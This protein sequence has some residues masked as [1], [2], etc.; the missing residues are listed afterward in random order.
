MIEG[1]ALYNK[2]LQYW[3]KKAAE[4]ESN[5][6]H[7]ANFHKVHDATPWM[8]DT[9]IG[10]REVGRDEEDWLDIWVWLAV[11]IGE[12]A[13]P[14]H[15]KLGKWYCSGVTVDGWCW[16]GFTTKDDMEKFISAFQFRTRTER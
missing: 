6:E 11:N 3:T 2:V 8:I 16:M 9:Y 1:S 13:R 4:K 5:R 7:L 14:L 12:E 10:S 15:E